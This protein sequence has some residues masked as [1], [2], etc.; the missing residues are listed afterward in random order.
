MRRRSSAADY[1]VVAKQQGLVVPNVH[2]DMS[3]DD[4]RNFVR[5]I[6]EEILKGAGQKKALSEYND[7]VT[8]LR[9][10][11]DVDLISFE[12]FRSGSRSYLRFDD[13]DL[14]KAADALHEL[15]KVTYNIVVLQMKLAPEKTLTS[16]EQ[17]NE[18]EPA[19]RRNT[20]PPSHEFD[21]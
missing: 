10:N 7:R 6:I 17:A 1:R 9:R 8:E 15:Q 14:K 11:F 21:S 16:E 19:L 4:R 3:V 5:A 20:V 13:Q 18:I 2:D 12:F